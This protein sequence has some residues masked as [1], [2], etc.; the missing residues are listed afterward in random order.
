MLA[1]VQLNYGSLVDMITLCPAAIVVMA[2]KKKG[3]GLCARVC[4]ET[5]SHRAFLSLS[6]HPLRGVIGTRFTKTIT[7]KKNPPLFLSTS[8][9]PE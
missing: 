8:K 6:N 2:G 4:T 7:P 1:S 5:H 3:A 9:G